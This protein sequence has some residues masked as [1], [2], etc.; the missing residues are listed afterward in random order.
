MVVLKLLQTVSYTMYQDGKQ[1][2]LAKI[3][4]AYNV[5]ITKFQLTTKHNVCLLKL[6]TATLLRVQ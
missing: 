4:A 3:L 5:K 6:F 2:I 1:V